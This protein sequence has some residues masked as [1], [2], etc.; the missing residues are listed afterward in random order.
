VITDLA[1]VGLKDPVPPGYTA[2]KETADSREQALRKHVLCVRFVSRKATN[3]A[4]VDITLSK[5]DSYKRLMNT[6]V[7]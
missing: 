4:V 7:G 1:L 6:L 3:S 2:I 5:D